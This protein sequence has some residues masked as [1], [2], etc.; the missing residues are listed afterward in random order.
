[1]QK[2]FLFII[3]TGLGFILLTPPE[4]PE[5]VFEPEPVQ[6]AVETVEP[7][8]RPDIAPKEEIKP[9]PVVQPKPKPVV[10][11]SNCYY[12]LLSQ[13]DWDV[14]TMQ[15]IMRAESGCNPTNHN[16]ADNHRSCKGS[17]GLLQIGCVHGYTVA[18]LSDPVNNIAAAYKI[19]K[20]QGYTAWTTY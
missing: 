7:L 19:Y 14:A 4:A 8:E 2:I 17:F 13:Y 18:Y 9:V 6:V 12:S 15:R 11:T 5:P 1:M 20:S 3:L 16:Y 10:D